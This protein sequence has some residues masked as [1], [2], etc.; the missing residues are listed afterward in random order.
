MLYYKSVVY[1]IQTLEKTLSVSSL[2]NRVQKLN[3]SVTEIDD[4]CLNSVSLISRLE[5]LTLWTC[6]SHGDLYPNK[7]ESVKRKQ[8]FSLSMESRTQYFM[9]SISIKEVLS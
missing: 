7:F 6:V 1:C 9:G 2:V 5:T 4:V 3:N 8:P